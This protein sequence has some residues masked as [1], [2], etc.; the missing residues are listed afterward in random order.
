M[1]QIDIDE[2]ARWIVDCWEEYHNRPKLYINGK[3][4]TYDY[5]FIYIF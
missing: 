3:E 4:Y 5:P 2:L 1:Q